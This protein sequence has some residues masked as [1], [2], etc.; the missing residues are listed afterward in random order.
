MLTSLPS[1]LL[2]FVR[3]NGNYVLQADL[4]CSQ[5]TIF[6][7]LLNYYIN[8]SGDELKRLF[9]KKPSQTFVKNL[10]TIFDDYNSEFPDNGVDVQNPYVDEYNVNDIYKFIVDALLNDFYGVIKSELN[11]Q[12]REHGKAIAFRTAF[13]KPKPENELVKQF[14]SVY[15]TIINIIND[16]K[17]SF[18]YN[19]FA[20]GLQRLESEI[21]IDYIW[22]RVKQKG[23]NSFTR[24]DS[25]VFPISKK[26]EVAEIIE[27][28]FSEFEFI[29]RVEYEEFNTE[30][31]QDRLLNETDYSDYLVDDIFPDEAFHNSNNNMMDEDYLEG[32]YDYTEYDKKQ[33]LL[34]Q[35][36]EVDLPT[37]IIDDYSEEV[38][39][40]VLGII[41]DL[42]DLD[43][44]LDERLALEE[45]IA[46][47]QSNFPVPF[48]QDKTNAVIK[49]LVEFKN[50]N[51]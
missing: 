4:K 43:L 18:G 2:P 45:D 47:L 26:K 16:F 46:N 9:Q 17:T 21:F 20:V 19:N 36:F 7:N 42:E 1:A 15:P 51:T 35:L 40:E 3:I 41:S 28:V 27:D 24:H 12:L 6:A 32:K 22:K 31:I 44:D 38:N 39:L 5:F 8:H 33:N 48:F 10:V 37:R 30:E 50:D 29:H 34:A 25:I 23:I 14:R 13:S 49:R 11:L